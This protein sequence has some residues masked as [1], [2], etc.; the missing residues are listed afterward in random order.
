MF[1][2]RLREAVAEGDK[3]RKQL[4]NSEYELQLL[5]KELASTHAEE[6]VKPVKVC[7]LKCRSMKFHRSLA[8]VDLVVDLSYFDWRNS[9][10]PGA[11]TLATEA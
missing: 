9:S 10:A 4:E 7:Y 2:I 8:A 11:T 6:K 5:K 1:W 3:L